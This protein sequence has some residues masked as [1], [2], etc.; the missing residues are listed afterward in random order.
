MTEM[1]EQGSV[2]PIIL[3]KPNE[4]VEVFVMILG[5]DEKKQYET[6]NEILLQ[7][8]QKLELLQQAVV[9]VIEDDVV[10]KHFHNFLL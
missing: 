4:F 1:D 8:Q 3:G 10:H 7:Q 6:L 5:L 9:V 2:K